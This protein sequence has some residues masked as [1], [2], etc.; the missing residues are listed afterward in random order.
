MTF[1]QRERGRS[2]RRFESRLLAGV[3]VVGGAAVKHAP[4]FSFSYDFVFGYAH[5]SLLCHKNVPEPQVVP[6]A[7]FLRDH[8]SF[9]EFVLRLGP[10]TSEKTF[11]LDLHCTVRC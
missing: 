5:E 4:A 3:I 8:S 10:R 11:A 9:A 1:P 7:R 2:N 6:P